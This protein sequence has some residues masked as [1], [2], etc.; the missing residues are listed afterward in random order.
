M[1]LDCK[2]TGIGVC[3]KDSISSA[4]DSLYI[5]FGGRMNTGSANVNSV[6]TY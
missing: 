4:M 1:T 5:I 3:G 2:D 6:L